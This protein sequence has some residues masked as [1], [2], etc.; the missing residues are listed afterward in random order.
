MAQRSARPARKD[1]TLCG[2]SHGLRV[3]SGITGSLP[4]WRLSAPEA[5]A[6]AVLTTHTAKVTRYQK[7][8]VDTR[9]FH[10]LA[11]RSSGSPL[12]DAFQS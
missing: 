1:G 11:Y 2:W 5:V 9:Q 10:M 6:A 7:K 4:V 3:A 12:R 8:C